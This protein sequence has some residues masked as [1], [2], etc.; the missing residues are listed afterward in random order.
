M[1]L[2]TSSGEVFVPGAILSLA[3]SLNIYIERG[4]S[5]SFPEASSLT[6]MRI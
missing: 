4:T 5:L 2:Q 1:K 6:R 3:E